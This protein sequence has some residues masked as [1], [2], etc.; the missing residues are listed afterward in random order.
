MTAC[1]RHL[2]H[3]SL[4]SNLGDRKA[5]ILKAVSI[6]SLSRI[7]NIIVS[8]IYETEPF[9][10]KA[11]PRFLNCV[12]KAETTLGPEELLAL[13]KSAEKQIGRT[14]TERWGPREIDADILLHGETVC[15][16]PG[17]SI[18]HP[19]M[20]R[21][22]FVLVP[23]CEITPKIMHPVLKCSAAVLLQKC[24]DCSEVIRYEY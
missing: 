5:A 16:A 22:R 8:S 18:P 9:G 4:G 12:L 10:V 3:L 23:L 17:L 6:L 7:E 14:G 15:D 21:R 2:I 1:D 24:E 19:E 20:H 13:C 11:Q